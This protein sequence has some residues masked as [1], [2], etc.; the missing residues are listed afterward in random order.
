MLSSPLEVSNSTKDKVVRLVALT[1]EVDDAFPSAKVLPGRPGGVSAVFRSSRRLF[2]S[3]L[4]V[5]VRTECMA[6]NNY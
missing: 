1:P 4:R 6:G 5:S 3:L 2:P